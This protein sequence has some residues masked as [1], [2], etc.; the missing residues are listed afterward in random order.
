VVCREDLIAL[1]GCEVVFALRWDLENYLLKYFFWNT[2]D[3]LCLLQPS[4][5]SV[6]IYK[7]W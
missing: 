7:C 5:L 1:E 3:V 4:C 2:F 6:D